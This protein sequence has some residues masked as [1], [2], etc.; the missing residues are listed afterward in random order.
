M[1]NTADHALAS[2]MLLTNEEL[3]QI[4]GAMGHINEITGGA[5]AGAALGSA[6]G[7]VGTLVGGAVGGLLGWL[8]G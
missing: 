8:L 3:D 6:F 7:P 4:G 1:T 5:A 2:P